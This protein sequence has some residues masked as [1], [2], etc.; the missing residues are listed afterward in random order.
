[1]KTTRTAIALLT[2]IA[3]VMTWAAPVSA[4]NPTATETVKVT[5]NLVESQSEEVLPGLS[6]K[7]LPGLSTECDDGDGDNGYLLM[8]GDRKGLVGGPSE[9]VLNLV[10]N[11]VTWDRTYPAMTPVTGLDG[12]HGDTVAGSL[13]ENTMYGGL[14]FN[15]DRNG[16]VTDVL[17]HFDYYLDGE[18]VQLNPRKT[19]FVWTVREYFTLTGND[20]NWDPETNTVSGDFYLMHSLY[21]AES[22]IGYEPVPGSPQPMAFQII[23]EDLD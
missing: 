20:L 2:V 23:I 3:L 1:M 22:E 18:T 8:T 10:M 15:I 11:G 16:A 17:W 12:C 6:E 9:A 14:G 4:G 5:M 13:M 19:Q 21:D 7:V